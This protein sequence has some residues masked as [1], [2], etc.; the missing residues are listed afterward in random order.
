MT[1]QEDFVGGELITSDGV[2][3]V[4]SVTSDQLQDRNFEQLEHIN[5]RVWISHQHRGDVEVE[6]VSPNGVRSVL[7]GR[8]NSD[9]AHSGFP[10]WTFMTVKHW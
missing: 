1:D 3:S 10:G 2:K 6:V 7:A 9:N 8:R 4:I 5:V